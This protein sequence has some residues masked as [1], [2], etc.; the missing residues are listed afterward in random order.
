[1]IYLSNTVAW[2]VENVMGLSVETGI[3]E[4]VHFFIFAT[5]EIFCTYDTNNNV[6]WT[7]K[8]FYRSSKD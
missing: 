7:I 2:L 4:V 8:K 5:I 3:G 6:H 1:M